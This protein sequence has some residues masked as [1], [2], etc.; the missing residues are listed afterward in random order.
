MAR[1]LTVTAR[2]T[3]TPNQIARCRERKA[4]RDWLAQAL[5]GRKSIF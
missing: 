5:A 1:W 4:R 3:Q 2:F